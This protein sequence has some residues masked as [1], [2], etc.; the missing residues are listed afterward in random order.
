MIL[1]MIE[2]LVCN[3]KLQ[4]RISFLRKGKPKVKLRD[5]KREKKE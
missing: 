1:N 2:W 3:E 5:T 4:K